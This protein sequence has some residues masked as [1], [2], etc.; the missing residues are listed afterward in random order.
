MLKSLQIADSDSWKNQ[1]NQEILL[2]RFVEIIIWDSDYWKNQ[3][4]EN[5]IK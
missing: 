2:S 4:T 3:K 1:K 5:Q